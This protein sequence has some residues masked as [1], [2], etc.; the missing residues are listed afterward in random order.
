MIIN[1][2]LATARRNLT[3]QTRAYP[4]DFF[5]S[6]LLT[7]F[8]TILGSFFIYNIVF[9]GNVTNEFI[10]YSGTSDYM[11]FTI[12]GSFMY[13]FVVGTFLNVSR[14]F[15]TEMREG[16]L[17]SLLI[18]PVN[19]MGYLSGNMLEQTMITAGELLIAILIT[20]PFGLR[21]ANINVASTMLS[22]ALTL[23][24][25]F[26]MSIILSGIMIYFK[27]TYLS[28]NTVFSIIYLT[29]GILFPIQ[30]L[31]S[32]LQV[33]SNYIPVTYSLRTL[34]NSVLTGLDIT[35]QYNDF[36]Q[37]AVLSIVYFTVGMLMIRRIV[38]KAPERQFI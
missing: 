34:R 1:N 14:S 29:T 20:I 38:K 23:I 8:F 12:L 31:P 19:Y 5:F 37:L 7:C 35:S 10:Q 30:Y 28:Q 2:I 6:K 13:L 15:I 36:K 11:S 22:I 21:F 4:V 18:S 24:A 16:T 9:K 17:D 26:G 27:D 32:W 33:I 25:L 3:M